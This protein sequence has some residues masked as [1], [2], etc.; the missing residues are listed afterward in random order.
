MYYPIKNLGQNFLTD[1]TIV[2]KMID[3]LDVAPED[4]IVEIGPGLGI[5]TEEL[6]NRLDRN[7][8][9]LYAVEIDERLWSKINEMFLYR[10]N[11]I[12][13]NE[14]ILEWF[15]DF[16]PETDYKII[17]S[18]PFYITSPI[19]HAIIELKKRP[20]LAVLMV[21]Y[22]VAKKIAAIKPD[23]SYLSV[24]TQTFFDVEYLGKISKK[25]FRPEPKVDGGL[26]RLIKREF[27]MAPDILN[28]YIGF[29]HKGFQ[30]PRKMLNKPFSKEQLELS[31]VNPTF[32]PQEL[33]AK[34][35]VNFFYTLSTSNML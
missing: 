35:W 1:M 15:K 12:A 32:R 22:E 18:L 33:S 13:V 5:L 7:N 26:I 11:V 3:A 25:Q 19:L 16:E 21:Q 24:I 2:R 4:K 29:L 17:G 34:E 6:S 27:D 10:G 28:K 20:I 23:S 30:S 31:G 9:K 14:D 8:S